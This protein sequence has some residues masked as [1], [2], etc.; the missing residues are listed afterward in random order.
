M[1]RK[2]NRLPSIK[3][4]KKRKKIV[5]GSSAHTMDRKAIIGSVLKAV[6]V[7]P[8]LSGQIS[9][10]VKREKDIPNLKN[11]NVVNIIPEAKQ[12]LRVG[13]TQLQIIGEK[14]KA[15]QI[16]EKSNIG[17]ISPPVQP[18]LYEK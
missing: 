16:L 15:K 11:T 14:N 9:T 3:Q 7:N 6:P 13:A 5:K 18:T 4:V 10:Y 8:V 1:F 17:I 12:T 2:Q